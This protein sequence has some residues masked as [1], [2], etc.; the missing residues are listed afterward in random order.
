[1]GLHSSSIPREGPADTWGALPS[2]S[3]RYERQRRAQAALV[4][5]GRFEFAT[6]D[7]LGA[8]VPGSSYRLLPVTRRTYF[9]DK[10]DYNVGRAGDPREVSTPK[11][12]PPRVRQAEPGTLSLPAPARS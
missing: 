12:A 2:W 11:L 6:F 7:E 9:S 4:G 1:M 3:Q 5:Q 8:P 10:R